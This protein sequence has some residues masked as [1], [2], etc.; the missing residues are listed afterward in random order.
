[1]NFFILA[2]SILIAIIIGYTLPKQRRKN[3]SEQQS[4]W[5]RE[6][7]SN[8]VRRKPLDSLD[9]IQIPFDTFPLE[10]MA[11]DI[12]VM[13]YQ[14]LIKELST[15]KIVNLTGY[16]NTDLKLEYGTANITPLSEYDQNYTILV[17]T[18]QQWADILY[19]AGYQNDAQ[20]LMEFALSTG[21]DVSR[22]YYKLADIYASRGDFSQ[23][24]VLKKQAENLRTSTKNIIV[25]TLQESY[26]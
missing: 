24:E 16:T 21:S 25:R 13:E 5:E 10:T 6:R 12:K 8:S 19:D 26:P 9:Y 20:I 14:T 11:E 2:S 17:R 3:A 7:A 4:F 1:M 23:I 22:T 15:Q 18:L